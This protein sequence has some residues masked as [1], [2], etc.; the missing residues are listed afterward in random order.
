[1]MTRRIHPSNTPQPTPPHQVLIP[2]AG[3]IYLGL[4]LKKY[5]LE[6]YSD[7]VTNDFLLLGFKDVEALRKHLAD[8]IIGYGGDSKF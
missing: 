1:M 4:V 6:G 7:L 3:L 5:S 8:N 2:F